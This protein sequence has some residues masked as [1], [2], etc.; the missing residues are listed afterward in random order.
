MRVCLDTNAYSKL[1][2]D[3]TDLQRCL[4]EA[5]LIYVPTIVLGELYAGFSLGS[6]YAE[7]CGDLEAFL[8]LPGIQVTPPDKEVAE[9]YGYLVRDLRQQGTPIPTNDLWIAATALET[10]AR[11]VSYDVHFQHVPGLIIIAP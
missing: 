3:Q 7:N 2:R 4:E 10:G 5:A 8:Q 9:R 6:H 11:L 1:M